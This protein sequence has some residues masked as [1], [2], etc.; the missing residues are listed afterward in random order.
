[1]RDRATRERQ[2]SG[3]GAAREQ[4]SE[5]V[6]DFLSYQTLSRKRIEGDEMGEACST[7]GND[8]NIFKKWL[9]PQWHATEL[10]SYMYVC[11]YTHT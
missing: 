4:H 9:E 5:K 8:K 3:K 2:E 1:V 10:K 7:H 11:S 6:Q